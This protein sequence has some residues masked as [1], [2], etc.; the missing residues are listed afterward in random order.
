MHHWAEQEFLLELKTSALLDHSVTILVRWDQEIEQW[1][2]AAWRT[3]ADHYSQDY[4]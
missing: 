4:H 1:K 3:P 2:G